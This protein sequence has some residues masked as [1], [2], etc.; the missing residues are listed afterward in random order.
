[1]SAEVLD[2]SLQGAD[3]WVLTN[4]GAVKHVSLNHQ[5]QETC[6]NGPESPVRLLFFLNNLVAVDSTHAAFNSRRFHLD[7]HFI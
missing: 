1:M 2:S 3:H 4:L 6:Q 7:G 5:A